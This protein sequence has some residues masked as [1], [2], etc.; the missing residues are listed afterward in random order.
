MRVFHYTATHHAREILVSGAISRGHIPVPDAAGEYLAGH[1]PGWQW[2][3]TDA[4]W[5]QSW[6]TRIKHNC[7]RT[8][9]RFV[10]EIPLLELH[11]LKR[12]DAVAA[13]Y[14]YTPDL[15]QQFAEIGGGKDSSHWYVFQG[16]IPAAWIVDLERRPN[17]VK[18]GGTKRARRRQGAPS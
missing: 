3:T 8:E 17:E 4:E 12:W 1:I 18:I 14:G 16:P 6:A 10:L 5:R 15:A 2:V 11:R 9:V 13:N 7:D